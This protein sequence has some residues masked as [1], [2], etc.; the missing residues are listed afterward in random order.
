MKG[1]RNT[2]SSGTTY[3]TAGAGG[4]CYRE[5]ARSL[6]GNSK[7]FDLIDTSREQLIRQL[8]ERARMNNPA[9]AIYTL[10]TVALC[11]AALLP[12]A[13][14]ERM[15]LP[16]AETRLDGSETA[17]LTV[18]EYS[19]LVARYGEPNSILYADA[20]P[21]AP[22]PVGSA[23]YEPARLRV[24]FVPRGCLDAYVQIRHSLEDLPNWPRL[25]KREMDR[26]AAECAASRN[27]AWSVVGYRDSLDGEVLS[28][29]TAEGRLDYVRFPRRT[30]PVVKLD[31]NPA[32]AAPRVPLKF[33]PS[34]RAAEEQ[35]RQTFRDAEARVMYQRAGLSAAALLLFLGGAA[36][37]GKNI[38]KRHS[39]LLYELNRPQQERHAAVQ[40]ALGLLSKSKRLWRV[41]ALAASPAARKSLKPHG[42][43]RRTAMGMRYLSPPRVR[44]NVLVPCLNMGNSSLYF[45]P[46]VILYANPRGYTGIDYDDL[47]IVYGVR[48]FVEGGRVPSDAKVVDRTWLYANKSGGPD[49]RYRKNRRLPVL[50]LGALGLQAS[51]VLNIEINTSSAPLSAAFAQAWKDLCDRPQRESAPPVASDDP[52][53][54]AARTVLGVSEGATE[55]EISAAYHRSAQMYHPDK[56]AGLAPEFQSVADAKM[57]EINAAY[58]VLRRRG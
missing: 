11:A 24:L 28:T 6:D 22:V 33:D 39:F 12:E 18:D 37:H 5:P 58:R 7:S 41:E 23:L 14:P 4:F 19:V 45:L 16:D 54:S 32:P 8:N 1:V 40:Q 17:P 2:S 51:R 47:E 50:E 25:A 13:A 44:T 36:L 43:V 53:T 26:G 31:R 55:A 42:L 48:P 30:A 57:R 9:W 35:A 46:D 3:I 56:V 27:A 15:V 20:A 49:R 34:Y 10:A 29:L 52:E 38:A 21:R